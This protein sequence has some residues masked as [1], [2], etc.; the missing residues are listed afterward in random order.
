MGVRANA[1]KNTETDLLH[2]TQT[3]DGPGPF[4]SGEVVSP[5]DDERVRKKAVQ[6]VSRALTGQP[7][8][9]RP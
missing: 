4:N 2:E 1:Y 3:S 6:L 9:P 7:R 5:F 8:A